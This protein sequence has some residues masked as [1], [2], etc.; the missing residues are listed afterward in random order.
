MLALGLMAWP[1]LGYW[2]AIEDLGIRWLVGFPLPWM[3][4]GFIG[5]GVPTDFHLIPIVIDLP[6]YLLASSLIWN[7]IERLSAHSPALRAVLR[8][9]VNLF[10]ALTLLWVTFP[11]LLPEGR[12][13]L[14][15]QVGGFRWKVVGVYIHPFSERPPEAQGIP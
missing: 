10:G 2:V 14:W 13:D 7:G 11:L 9:G 15:Y 12:G 6:L 1:T 8:I 3:S 4:Q 5:S